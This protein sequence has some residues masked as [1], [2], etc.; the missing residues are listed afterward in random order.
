M[1]LTTERRKQ[2]GAF[3]TPPTFAQLCVERLHE[4]LPSFNDFVFYDPAAGEGALLDALPEGTEKYASTLELED[5]EILKQKGYDAEQF[6]FLR[7]NTDF[8]NPNILNARDE[9]RL[10]V[11]TNP[12]FFKLPKENYTLMKRLYPAHCHDSVCLF[13]LRIMRELQP[14]ILATWSKMDIYQA[15]QLQ[16]F[17]KEFD[18][19]RRLIRNPIMTNSKDWGLKGSFPIVFSI[20]GGYWMYPRK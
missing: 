11:L 9:G 7:M 16:S 3:Y 20:F 15:A 10:I 18:P 5:V 8:L 4:V 19:M 14:C 17:R 13:L 1:E 6:D 12:P 2:T